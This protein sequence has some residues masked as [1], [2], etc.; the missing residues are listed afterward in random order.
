MINSQ[1]YPFLAV[2]ESSKI[3]PPKALYNRLGGT[4][5]GEKMK[6]TSK[7]MR[8]WTQ[9]SL[10][11]LCEK[12]IAA[13]TDASKKNSARMKDR[14]RQFQAQRVTDAMHNYE[15]ALGYMHNEIAI[16]YYQ[17]RMDRALAR[18]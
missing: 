5:I 6:Y 16:D 15:A 4:L 13:V 2:I 18:L 9:E 8:F 12:S 14:D 11:E 17:N 3:S 1:D 10:K 7:F